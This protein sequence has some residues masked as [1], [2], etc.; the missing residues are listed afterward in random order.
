MSD[1]NLKQER[2]VSIIHSAVAQ[3]FVE[4]ALDWGIAGLPM[5]EQVFVSPDLHHVEVWLSFSPWKREQAERDF[6]TVNRHLGE[7][8]KF[9]ATKVDFRRF[10]ELVLRLADPDK[11]FKI[12]DIL[13]TI[14]G[15]EGTGQPNSADTRTSEEDSADGTH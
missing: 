11:A 9:V 13:G 14:S 12:M 10:P 2:M 3:F 8:K 7:L 4:Q 1:K 5:V 6:E 15:H